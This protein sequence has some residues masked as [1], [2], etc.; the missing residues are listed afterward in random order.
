MGVTY[1]TQRPQELAQRADAG[2]EVVR[3]RRPERTRA[4]LEDFE[5]I[6]SAREALELVG[7]KWTVDLMILMASGIRRHARLFENAP[8]ISKKMLNATLRTLVESGLVARSVYDEVPVRVEYSLTPLGWKA[9]ELVLALSEWA[10]E[11][12]EELSEARSA[13]PAPHVLPAR[14]L[15]AHDH[16]QVRAA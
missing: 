14:T 12:R 2:V 3:L 6:A 15:E 13:R 4:R 5:M 7:S 10:D 1:E 11:H 16:R 9:T 8:G